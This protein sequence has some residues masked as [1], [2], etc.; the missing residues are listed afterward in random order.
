M[1]DSGSDADDGFGVDDIVTPCAL[2]GANQVLFVFDTCYSGEAIEAGRLATE[3]MRDAQ[4]P[5]DLWVGVLSSC[6]PTETARDGLFGRRLRKIVT[7]GPDDP[8]L[9]VRW[10]P[11]N[12]FVRGD[13]V[14]DAV[15]KEWEGGVQCPDF[16]SRGNA[17]WMFPNPLYQPGAPEQVV[18]HLLRAARG[19]TSANERSWFTGRTDQVNRVVGWVEERRPGLH[20]VTGSAGTGKSAIV[21]QVVSLSNPAERSRLVADGRTWHHALPRVRS[22]DAHVHA[23]GLTAD[24]AADFLAGQLVQRDVLAQQETRRNAS[25]LVGQVQRAVEGGAKPPVIVIDGLDEARGEAFPIA[26]ELLI[27]LARHAVVI[28]STREVRQGG[29]SP[30]LV[31]TLAP[32]GPEMDLDAPALERQSRE[33]LADYVLLRLS[34]IDP[35]MN[36]AAVAAHLSRIT[37]AGRQPFLLARLVTD[38][39]SA[40][41]V[42]TSAEGWRD[43]VSNSIEKALDSDL[44]D[45][46]PAPH[47]RTMASLPPAD[48]AR[49]ILRTLT[50]GYGAGLPEDEWITVANSALPEAITVTRED[51]TWVLDQLGRHV[52]QDGETGVVVYRMAHQSLADHLRRP[53]QSSAVQPFDSEALAVAQALFT[54]YRALLEGGV[55]TEQPVYLWRYAWRHAAAAGVDGL[56]LLRSLAA[57]TISLQPDVALAAL[58]ISEGFGHWGR[59]L[60][61]VD[62]AEEAVRIYR[63]L[64]RDDPAYLPDLGMALNNLGVRYSTVGRRMEA[65]A[66]T[67]E[68]LHLYRALARDDPAYLPDLGMALNNLGIRYS[69]VGRRM[70]AVAPT[71]ES[72]ILRRAL[73]KENPAYL[74]DLANALNSLGHC[75][76]TVGR[77]MEAVAPTEEALH[78]YRALARDDPAYLPDLAMAL[79]NLGLCY[80]EVGRRME[81]V[82]P[83]EEAVLL[84]RALVRDNPAYL[85]N[86]AHTLN[87]LGMRYGAVGRRAEAVDPAEEAVRLYRALAEENPAHLP[88]LAM[89]L[90]SLGVRYGAVGRRV[91]AVGPAEESVLLRRALA[92]DNPAY[93]SDL[94]NALDNLGHCYGAVGRRVEAVGP[95]E[96]SVSLYRALVKENPAHL[97]D[98]AG[99]LNI[100]GQCYRAVGRRVE[101]VDPIEEAVLLRRALAKENPAH[102]PYLAGALDSLGICYSRVGRRVEA[103]GPAEESVSLYRALVKENLAH[104]PDLAGALNNLGICYSVAGKSV[105]AVDS[106]EEAVLLRRALVKE[107]PAYLP[108]LAGALDNLSMRYSVVGRRVE[109][110]DL[111]EEAIRLYRALARDNPAYLADLAMALNNLGI[112]YSRVGRR[113]EAVGPA[114]E[115]VSLYRA[116]AKENPAYLPDLAGALNNLGICYSV[117]GESVEAVW[118]DVLRDIDSTSA[119][120]LLLCR[121][122]GAQA[123]DADAV[124]WVATVAVTVP[125]HEFEY[126]G[127][128]HSEGRRH[129]AA[130]PEEFDEAWSEYTGMDPPNWLSVDADLLAMAESWVETATY[131]AERDYLAAHPELLAPEADCAVEEALL[132]VG[133]DAERFRDIRRAAKDSSVEDVYRPL[134]LRVLAHRFADADPQV[135]RDMLDDQRTDLLD[136]LVLSELSRAVTDSASDGASEFAR[137]EALLALARSGEQETA[138]EALEDPSLFPD[139]LRSLA[140]RADPA[141]LAPA[142]TLALDAATSPEGAATAVFHLAV[143]SAIR[144]ENDQAR[145]LLEAACQLLPDKALTWINEL[146]DIGRLHSAVL[147]L[148][149]VL[150]QQ[151]P[152]RAQ[153]GQDVPN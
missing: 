89:A 12:R 143:A 135:Q 37:E 5:H 123:G 122:S 110:V 9:R 42:D 136:D 128:L 13:D 83:I 74:P 115:S 65:V 31:S 72:V 148:I 4:L 84:R 111:T 119:A 38:Q 35:R 127:I 125:D 86:L 106:A 101:A 8:G 10:S 68:A 54:R 104:L 3:I 23:R 53:Y 129:R 81:A 132:A 144:G 56:V 146:A 33:D 45:I 107:N 91:E 18:E 150:T 21:G 24:L 87:N 64:A 15:L 51:I 141:L 29:N 137:A 30:S 112:C 76:S 11:H 52:V 92:R 100:L 138:F 57:K 126:L 61:A 40:T 90:G 153:G 28:V 78:I 36:G 41:P 75:Y 17:W 139:L 121:A 67:E 66:P 62:P 98:L 79:N 151:S 105:E 63:A 118:A 58:A 43:K 95:A 97:S 109:A 2:S 26:E 117:A 85:P 131:A 47:R 14:C 80:S 142:A 134:L 147:T 59:R 88:D 7:E 25:E 48:L 82:D 140:R 1:A 113:V 32:A 69:T 50:W 19:G 152:S 124:R 34:R 93:L 94:A 108:H 73:A 22:V 145:E 55:P 6:L 149:P 96:E 27:R 20:V 114:E 120:Y 44:A 99:A 133:E 70:E 77:R 71:E 103:V 102:L 46:T 116:L 49:S 16:Q 39:L 60:E 130:G